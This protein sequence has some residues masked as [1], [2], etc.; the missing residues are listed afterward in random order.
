MVKAAI[1]KEAAD[2]LHSIVKDGDLIGTV[3]G[4]TIHLMSTYVEHKALKDVGIVQ[5]KGGVSHSDKKT[6]ASETLHLLEKA[7]DAVSYQ[8]PL[9]AIVDHVIVKQAI[10]ADRHIKN[11]LNMGKK[12]NIAVFTVGV[13]RMDSLLFQLG[14]FTEDEKKIITE[15]AVGDIASRFFDKEGNICDAALDAKTIGIE[16]DELKTQM[17]KFQNQKN[18]NE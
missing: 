12:A 17:I 15:H 6:F 4:T 14:Y 3:W 18:E 13:P 8:L 16:L 2:Y 10:E 5:L 11:L 7:F 9:P 1:G